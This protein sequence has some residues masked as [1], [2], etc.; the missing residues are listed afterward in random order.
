METIKDNVACLVA[1]HCEILKTKVM[2]EL[3]I[4]EHE[5]VAQ[6][7]EIFQEGADIFD[8]LS[9]EAQHKSFIKSNF[10]HVK[11][12]EV[13]LGN[14]LKR[15]RKKNEFF[16]TEKQETFMYVPILETLEQ[17]LNNARI[18]SLIIRKPHLTGN[19][20]YYD[21][22]DG[23]TYTS[24]EF[25]KE[26]PDALALMLFHDEL[27]ICNPLCSAAT[28]YKIDMYYYCVANISPKY[29]S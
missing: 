18:A 25:F 10:S 8:G 5:N 14:I 16:L 26:H 17:M 3:D 27:E 9:T 19:G 20:Y 13:A 6:L 22:F 28:K 23:S 1:Q 29:R 7:N 4:T 12:V 21:I 2:Q 11:P 24:D 15:K